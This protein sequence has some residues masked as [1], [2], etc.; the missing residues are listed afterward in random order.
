MKYITIILTVLS[1]LFSTIV[2]A[3][4]SL[5]AVEYYEEAT[6]FLEETNSKMAVIALQKAIE[7]DSLLYDAY[8]LLAKLYAF[9][10]EKEKVKEYCY[11][12]LSLKQDQKEPHY[13]LATIYGQEDELDSSYTHFQSMTHLDP[14]DGQAY[15]GMAQIRTLQED[16]D[17]AMIYARKAVELTESTQS[18]N[19][20]KAQYLR[21]VLHYY[22][23]EDKQAVKYLTTA[24]KNGVELEDN[25]LEFIMEYDQKVINFESEADFRRSEKTLVKHYEFILNNPAEEGTTARLK[26]CQYILDWVSTCPYITVQVTQKLVPYMS[27]GEGLIVFM[28]GWAKYCIEGGD[29]S[30]KWKGCL[31]ATRDVLDYYFTN[32]EELG[33]NKDL[34]K[35]AKRNKKNKLEQYI[36]DNIK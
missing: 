17:A 24:S 11:K 31:A 2:I 14:D 3:Q 15:L 25:L 19:T 29:C 8:E 27:Y 1:G 5:K 28:G 33:K 10:G 26:S 34:E 4:D 20:G 7:A 6:S 30:E 23:G 22:L 36:R 12:A 16:Y 21:G 18:S 9:D 32:K 13:F 35:M